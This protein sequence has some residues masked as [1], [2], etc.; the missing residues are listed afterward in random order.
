M[1]REYLTH[2]YSVSYSLFH[3]VKCHPTR[4]V[5]Q[6]DPLS[7]LLFSMTMDE[8]LTVLEAHDSIYFDGHPLHYIAYADDLII[9][10]PSAAALQNKLRC[11]AASLELAGLSINVNK[12]RTINIVAE[13]QRKIMS[14]S[15]TIFNINCQSIPAIS[16]TEEFTY[17]GVPFNYKDRRCLDHVGVLNG[18]LDNRK[19]PPLK[20]HQRIEILKNNLIPRLLYSLTLSITLRNTL[21]TMDK[22]IRAAVCRWLHLPKDAPTAFFH[23]DIKKGDLEIMNLSATIPRHRRKRVEALLNNR[24]PLIRSIASSVTFTPFFRICNLPMQAHR[25]KVTSAEEAR[26]SWA[27]QLHS[28]ADG[29]GLMELTTCPESHKW[30]LN[31]EMGLPKLYIRALQ[32]RGGL[33]G[34]KT[35]N[36]RGCPRMQET[37]RRPQADRQQTPQIQPQI[38]HRATRCGIHSR[39]NNLQRR[40]HLHQPWV[41]DVKIRGSNDGCCR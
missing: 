5:K 34:T 13:R 9:L 3:E 39:R 17:L 36:A 23:A 2:Y 14:L 35:R 12:S 8:I 24:N 22:L 15:P 33:L 16:P 25:Q 7:P 29:Y 38:L 40:P 6:G 1:L 37:Q 27:Q 4:G 30:L 19:R 10:A 32:L 31:P 41:E 11:I 20:P 18:Y 21:K 26:E 28:S